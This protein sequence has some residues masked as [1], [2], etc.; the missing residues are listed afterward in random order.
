MSNLT[1]NLKFGIIAP[2]RLSSKATSFLKDVAA[3][4]VVDSKVFLGLQ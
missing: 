2:A 3:N 4:K 1:L